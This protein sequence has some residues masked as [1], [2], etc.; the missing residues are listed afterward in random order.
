MGPI[1]VSILLGPVATYGDNVNW[2]GS[3][4]D[5]FWSTVGNWSASPSSHVPGPAD[6]V[7][8]NLS[9]SGNSNVVNS[10][11][12]IGPLLYLGS[13]SHTTDFNGGSHL[14]VNGN[15]YIG[16][17]GARDGRATVTWTNGGF[18]TVGDSATPRHVSDRVQWHRERD[19]RQLVDAQ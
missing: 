1:L 8:F 3:G 16:Y 12:T 19:E 4:G 15:A 5:D 13:S 7:F 10:D 18:V 9:D 6:S 11:F 17:G 2:I 14:Q